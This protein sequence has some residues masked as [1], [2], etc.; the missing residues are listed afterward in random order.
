MATHV[1]GA[2][3]FSPSDVDLLQD[4]LDGTG[5]REQLSEK[6]AEAERD[7]SRALD[8]V[9]DTI[10]RETDTFDSL[11]SHLNASDRVLEGLQGILH[12]TQNQLKDV[13]ADIR[14][15]H[16]AAGGLSVQLGQS[17]Q[18]ATAIRDAID[19]RLVFPDT[20]DAVLNG[21]VA[22]PTFVSHLEKLDKVY[23]T[24]VTPIIV[25]PSQRM[26]RADSL[27]HLHLHE[28]SSEAEISREL[29]PA[30]E[31][32]VMHAAS[33][34]RNHL[35]PRILHLRKPRTNIAIHQENVLARHRPLVAFLRRR[36]PVA[37]DEIRKLYVGILAAVYTT[38]FKS[39][40][41]NLNKL[42]LRVNPV[43]LAALQLVEKIALKGGVDPIAHAA[44]YVVAEDRVR[45][46]ER[47]LSG[48]VIV[49]HV[50]KARGGHF[51]F[52][53]AFHSIL[54]VLCDVVTHEYLFL[55]D[56]FSREHHV[57]YLHELFTPVVAFIV[58][59][60]AQWVCKAD[61][62]ISLL[63]L[64][65]TV[66]RTRSLMQRRR[67]PILHGLF[68]S[69]LLHLWPRFKIVFDSHVTSMRNVTSVDLLTVSWEHMTVHP[70]TARYAEFTA[71]LLRFLP[72]CDSAATVSSTNSRPSSSVEGPA[73]ANVQHHDPNDES[74]IAPRL[75]MLEANIRFVTIEYD[76]VILLLCGSLGS[77]EQRDITMLNNY[78]HVYAVWL[79]RGVI[80][81]MLNPF[82]AALDAQMAT[83]RMSVGQAM[84]EHTLPRLV[85]VVRENEKP[86][87][88]LEAVEVAVREMHSSWRPALDSLHQRIQTV[89]VHPPNVVEVLKHACMQLLLYNTR[90]NAIVGRH[91]RNP[92]FRS[93]VVSNQR[94]LQGMREVS[95]AL[96]SLGHDHEEFQDG[97]T[98]GYEL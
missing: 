17:R 89:V 40:V 86:N 15:L 34:V 74:E 61:D 96:T 58:E 45:A 93:C 8:S 70:M 22:T 9:A 55:F 18:A 14:S 38:K 11:N 37:F 39:Y 63:A 57:E 29:L 44:P 67:I 79:Q 54:S 6:V 80:E 24:L 16:D 25:T 51:Y 20:I 64:V 88:D 4:L 53:E 50:E 65:C 1:D 36:H 42:T 30:L 98:D 69:L 5:T 52:E 10:I 21:D 59:H 60:V 43:H 82:A 7:L 13:L 92:S 19:A 66:H 2:L 33:R 75:A 26:R 76:H 31:R 90:L 3:E 56:F 12:D 41:T 48:D 35:V 46:V 87:P 47:S 94:L 95:H 91:W 84:V 83:L 28:G 85:R 73:N 62:H 78:Y 32:L 49:Y 81:G 97:M 68:D 77:E 72:L 23:E 27:S 71:G